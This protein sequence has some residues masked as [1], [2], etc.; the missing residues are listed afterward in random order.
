MIRGA[1]VVAQQ[2]LMFSRLSGSVQ[3]VLVN[4]AAGIVSLR[5][6]GEPFSVMGFTIKSG[7]IVEIDVLGDPARP[8]GLIC[9]YSKI[10]KQVYVAEVRVDGLKD[11]G[12][13]CRP[14]LALSAFTPPLSSHSTK[15]VFRAQIRLK[16]GEGYS[17]PG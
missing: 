17:H 6:S 9:R 7:K 2:A 1:R 3:R 10:D 11:R 4:G 8:A 12:C 15:P 14:Q 16:G 13:R 5:P